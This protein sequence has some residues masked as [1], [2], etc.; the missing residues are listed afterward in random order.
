MCSML[1]SLYVLVCS[2]GH[3]GCPE[4]AAD[5]RDWG[6]VYHG[7][8]GQLVKCLKAFVWGHEIHQH[9]CPVRASATLGAFGKFMNSLH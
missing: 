4:A 9:V 2:Q 6:S 1:L 3:S 7:R 5:S 8:W